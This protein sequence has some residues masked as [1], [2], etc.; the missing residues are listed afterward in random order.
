MDG[1]GY[2]RLLRRTHCPRLTRAEELATWKRWKEDWDM[3]A[4][5]QLILSQLPWAANLA[6]RRLRYSRLTA[7]ELVSA[8]W[9]GVIDGVERFN[10]SRGRLITCVTFNIWQRLAF[11]IHEARCIVHTPIR[12]QTQRC[13]SHA[14]T[15]SCEGWRLSRPSGE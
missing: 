14:E 1:A 9:L 12:M 5:E 2:S 15:D 13:Y 11:A 4:R 6:L 3:D 7:D 8:A 10:P